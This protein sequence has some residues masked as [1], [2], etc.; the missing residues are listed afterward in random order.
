MRGVQGMG[1]AHLLFLHPS[2]SAIV[3]VAVAIPVVVS[4]PI[5]MLTPLVFAPLVFSLPLLTP[6]MFAPLALGYPTA[7]IILPVR[8]VSGNPV[9]SG[10]WVRR[11][12]GRV[13]RT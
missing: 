4:I 5:A 9:V 11:L 7:R 2:G 8:I 12:V 6:L 3:S 13:Y 10:A 1:A